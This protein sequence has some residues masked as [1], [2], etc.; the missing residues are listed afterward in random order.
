MKQT[1]TVSMF[2]DAF[3]RLDR[4]NQFSY[5]GL[6]ALF[7]HLEELEIDTGQEIELDVIALCCTFFEY[8][9]ID[10]IKKDYPDVEA[11]ADL[12][13]AASMVIEFDGGIIIQPD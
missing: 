9:N 3:V 13:A 11:V 1:I 4:K 7:T 10:E 2:R 5:D 8:E 12:E 6:T